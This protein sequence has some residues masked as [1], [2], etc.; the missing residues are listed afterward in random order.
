MN[1]KHEKIYTWTIM[2]NQINVSKAKKQNKTKTKTNKQKTKTKTT[3]KLNKH[4]ILFRSQII[5]WYNFQHVTIYNNNIINMHR[6]SEFEIKVLSD[7]F[8]YQF[9]S[10]NGNNTLSFS[11]FLYSYQ[12]NE[13][14]FNIKPVT[15]VTVW[16]F[17]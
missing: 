15:M 17:N 7:E 8:L 2:C 1:K 10:T 13:E 5:L 16:L 9:V 12:Y 6:I 4:D 14:G 3:K 11:H